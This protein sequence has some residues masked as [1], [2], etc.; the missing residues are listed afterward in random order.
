MSPGT[1]VFS[2]SLGIEVNISQWDDLRDPKQRQLCFFPHFPSPHLFRSR[3]K[4][5][6]KNHLPHSPLP[7]DE[8]LLEGAQFSI[9]LCRIE[10]LFP[11]SRQEEVRAM[12]VRA[13]W[14]MVR[15]VEER[16]KGLQRYCQG[17]V[18]LAP[19]LNSLPFVQIIEFLI[20]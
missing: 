3:L 17:R 11:G 4:I 1:V 12:T 20:V 16:T 2:S 6:R 13:S 5:L 15:S 7:S 19:G 14:P 8:L 18:C 10:T 9:C